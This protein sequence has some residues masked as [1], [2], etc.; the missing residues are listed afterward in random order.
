MTLIQQNAFENV[1]YKMGPFNFSLIQQN[2]FNYVICKMGP[3]YFCLNVLIHQQLE[4]HGCV[5]IP[6]ATDGVVLK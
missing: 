4:L 5:I 2:A 6:V 1:V 3:F